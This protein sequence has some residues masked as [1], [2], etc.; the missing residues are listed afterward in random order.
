MGH[1]RTAAHGIGGT[2]GTG[3][4]AGVVVGVDLGS[5]RIKVGAYAPDGSQVALA[6]VPT[7]TT[8]NQGMVDFP[9]L[10]MLDAV[11]QAVRDL[12][13][14]EPVRG[15]GVGSMGEVGTLLVD[16]RL[17]DLDFPA[18]YDER[19]AAEVTALE[20][21]IERRRLDG[22]TGGHVRAVST[23]AKLAWRRGTGAPTHGTFLGVAGAVCWR[24]TGAATQ[25][26]SLACTSGAFDPVRRTWWR[27]AWDAAGLAEVALPAVSTPGGWAPARGA[28]ARAWNLAEGSP[29][30]VAGHDHLV[31]AVGSGARVGD[32]VDSLGTGE[33]VLAAS[34]ALGDGERVADLVARG[35]TVE[36]WPPTGDPTVA[37]E[38]LR[39][40]LAM[41]AFVQASGLQREDL[42]RLAPAPG[43][44]PALDPAVVA[45]MEA[46]QAPR[47]GP[48]EWAALM[49][50]Y[51]QQATHGD[52]L[53]REITG[54]A[55]ATLVTGGGT[56][57]QRW[58]AAK[59]ALA[60][61][62][63]RVVTT[64]ETAARGA[65]AMA[66]AA[67]GWWPEPA[68]MGGL[69]ILTA[70]RTTGISRGRR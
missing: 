8:V 63:L 57:S 39:P 54:A 19:G 62:A 25:E 18:W 59:Q 32:V 33:P 3:T 48:Q 47:L 35:L 69:E 44:A 64:Q 16:D 38:G 41:A 58:L 1:Q 31:A 24:L 34:T 45:S 46:G 43:S 40:G 68:A 2:D 53:L 28:G 60:G 10:A 37:F 21:R 17:V 42:D 27:D 49:D 67:L 9:V 51:A 12:G 7:P 20:A 65:A 11:D 56:R 6:S 29:V 50:H 30:L 61:G 66:G 15:V 22:R 5:S 23:L 26:A 55:G 70:D 52:R 13:L 36:C 14:D 4:G